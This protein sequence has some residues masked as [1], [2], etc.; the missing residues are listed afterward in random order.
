MVRVWGG[1]VGWKKNFVRGEGGAGGMV[2]VRGMRCC[3]L[4]VLVVVGG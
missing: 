4:R 3:F 2:G 1:V